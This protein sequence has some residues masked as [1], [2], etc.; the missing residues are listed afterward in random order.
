MRWVKIQSISTSKR[1][2]RHFSVCPRT[3]FKKN[4]LEFSWLLNQTLIYFRRLCLKEGHPSLISHTRDCELQLQAMCIFICNSS[5]GFL[6]KQ[7]CSNE[8]CQNVILHKH[9]HSTVVFLKGYCTYESCGDL[10]KMQIK[11][12]RCGVGQEILLFEQTP[13]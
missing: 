7:T 2:C 11:I 8:S 12:P 5:I 3:H 1:I 9:Q 13:R 6:S 4:I 10:V